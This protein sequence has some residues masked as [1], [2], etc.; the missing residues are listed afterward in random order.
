MK[1]IALVLLALVVFVTLSLAAEIVFQPVESSL[2]SRA[3]YDAEAQIMAVHMVENSNI[4]Y[5]KGVPQAIYD[6]FVAAES[7]GA[8]YNENVK[9]KFEAA[10]V[11]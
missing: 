9:G 1:T 3:G 4:F 6:G 2:I 7:K 11:Q 10:L 5:Y 8:Y